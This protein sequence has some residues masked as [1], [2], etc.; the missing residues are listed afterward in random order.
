MLNVTSIVTDSSLSEY[1]GLSMY[2]PVVWNGAYVESYDF[3]IGFNASS[4]SRLSIRLAEDN[5]HI[6]NTSIVKEHAFI[7]FPV[8]AYTWYGVVKT[9][10]DEYQVRNTDEMS[11]REDTKD[12]HDSTFVSLESLR[13]V[14][15]TV[16][17]ILSPLGI[18]AF[19][20]EDT[21]NNVINVYKNAYDSVILQNNAYFKWKKDVG[22]PWYTF[23]TATENTIFNYDNKTFR[24]VYKINEDSYFNQ[25]NA[26]IWNNNEVGG[27]C[28]TIE[29]YIS[30]VNATWTDE[31]T[32]STG[33]ADYDFNIW[34]IDK[35]SDQL[36]DSM[37]VST[38]IAS[39]DENFDSSK[40]NNVY[41][42]KWGEGARQ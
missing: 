1:T 34:I 5:S 37:A 30:Q 2:T 31:I 36:V 11:A 32:I 13:S 40:I 23:K 26:D 17:C 27:L 4:P 9:I 20:Q 7:S 12:N 38:I 39:S 3:Q 15:D 41:S 22:M 35:N 28:E 19:R 25:E 8:G 18:T 6:L 42:V 14:A 21:W 33:D 16:K 10:D 24:I 29:S